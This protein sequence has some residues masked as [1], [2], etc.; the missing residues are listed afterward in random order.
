MLCFRANGFARAKST[1]RRSSLAASWQGA[2]LVPARPL[3]FVSRATIVICWCLETTD[4]PIKSCGRATFAGKCSV[5]SCPLAAGSRR[6]FF[7]ASSSSCRSDPVEPGQYVRVL[8]WECNE[9]WAIVIVLC[10][11]LCMP[12]G[13]CT[14][15][16]LCNLAEP[17]A[18]WLTRQ[19]PQRQE[20][21]MLVLSL[22]AVHS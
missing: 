10:E 7:F 15:R 1:R 9:D 13:R 8:A 11:S 2:P 18:L 6:A 12:L 3:S 16:R 14:V 19:T 22:L 21:A 4:R 17:V 20:S 5:S